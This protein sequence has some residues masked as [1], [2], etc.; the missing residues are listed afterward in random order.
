MESQ[1]GITYCQ[2]LPLAVAGT[3]GHIWFERLGCTYC[4]GLSRPCSHGR[5]YLWVPVFGIAKR[6]HILSEYGIGGRWYLWARGIR[7]ARRY[8]LSRS[9]KALHWRS[10]VS[11][12]ASVWNRKTGS[13]SV[14]VWHCRSLVLADARNSPLGHL[15]AFWAS[16]G[17]P[18]GYPGAILGP[19]VPLVLQGVL[20]GSEISPI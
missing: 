9:V 10:R 4:E 14:M 15:G 13:H 12:G 8:M 6:D 17:H 3:R 18:F 19:S 5:E 7:T 16:W 1:S 20:G 2:G 11:V